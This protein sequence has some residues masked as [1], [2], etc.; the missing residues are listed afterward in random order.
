M[1][2]RHLI[3]L[4]VFATLASC[5]SSPAREAKPCP[6]ED[7]L[8]QLEYYSATKPDSVLQILD[9]LDVGVLSEKERA[10]YCLMKVKVR[11]AFFLYDNETDS[12]LQI[13]ENYFIGG[14]DKWF[15]AETCEALSRIAS[16]EGKGEQ[17]KLEWLFKALQSM[18]QCHHVDERLI[19]YSGIDETQ[20]ERILGYQNK[21]RMRLGMCYLDNGYYH[22]GLRCLKEADQYFVN[23]QN[24]Y[25]HFF[26]ANA[27]GEAYLALREYDSCRVCF[28][29]GLMA[30][31]KN[32]QTENIAGY[33]YSMSMLYR[34]QIEN[35]DYESEEERQQLLYHAIAE[36][37]QGLA[38]FEGP[39]FRYKDALFS[40][41]SK[42]YYQLPQYDS[43]VY[44]AE[45][46]LDFM[47]DMNF[48]IVPNFEN[49][50][51]FCRL[52]KSYQALD[53]KEEALK[54]VDRYIDLLQDL[55]A[56]STDVE[57]VKSDYEKKMEM[58][59]LQNEQQ[60]KRYRLYLLL[61]FVLIAFLVVLWLANRY[62]KNKEIESIRQAESYRKLQSEFDAAS[63]HSLQLLQQRVLAIYQSG[64]EQMM[65]RIMAEFVAAYPQATE[66]LVSTYPN[67]TESERNIVILSFLGFRMKE[68]AEILNLSL[69]TVEKYRTNIRKK[70]GSDPISFLI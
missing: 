6:Q 23:I 34:R 28:E 49:A 14:K 65:E 29:N 47:K 20:K 68:E 38:L 58:M 46:Q 51:I 21:I 61:A 45:K 22:D 55:G 1:N 43:C 10:H 39:L 52:Y 37:H 12:L 36:C 4:I 66:K 54:Y 40:E 7:K 8:Y 59:Q 67:L 19:R 27:M 41:L 57:H 56:R 31:Q 15:E 63:Q 60:V 44:Y 9:T 11:D 3:L 16:K 69:N 18:E 26:S 62:R 17:I 48:D 70:A 24:N 25:L 33:H 53:R 2:K 64:E 50:D 30:S 5:T 35:Q 32:G 42:L 13:A